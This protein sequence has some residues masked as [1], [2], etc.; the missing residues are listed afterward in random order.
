MAQHHEE[1]ICY[2]CG[3]EVTPEQWSTAVFAHTV[4][5]HA[6]A[7][8]NRYICD[9]HTRRTD[10]QVKIMQDG[11]R[12]HRYHITARSCALCAPLRNAGGLV[13]MSWWLA[14]FVTVV[15]TG[16]FLYHA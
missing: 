4:D 16:W 9:A 15:L 10:E 7:G 13:G 8:C 2:V 1:Y 11:L 14:G 12:S 3:A 5:S 6:C